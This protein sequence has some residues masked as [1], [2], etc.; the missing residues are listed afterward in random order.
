MSL[1]TEHKQPIALP[2][3]DSIYYPEVYTEQEAAAIFKELKE[4]TNWQQ[5]QIKMYGKLIDCPR[6]SAYFGQPNTH[7]TYSTIVKLSPTP[8]TKTLLALKQK[9]EELAKTEFNCMLANYYRDGKDSMSWHADGEPELGPE[10]IV[11]SVT[12]GAARMFHL[13]H[14][15]DASKKY[16]LPLENGSILVMGKRTQHEWLHQVP[17]TAKPIGE[18]INL[19]FRYIK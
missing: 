8:F 14:Q 9:A 2:D 12:F 5:H 7:Y 1:F 18:R 10:P 3:A 16:K 4:Q 11:A 15:T 17:K 6:L 19:T 13:K